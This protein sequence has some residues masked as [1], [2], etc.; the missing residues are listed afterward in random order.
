MKIKIMALVLMVLMVLTVAAC[1]TP[2]DT[3]NPADTTPSQGGTPSGDPTVETT[4]EAGPGLEAVDYEG[5]EFLVLNL[6]PN[7]ST[8]FPYAEILAE[9][10]DGTT[11]NDAVYE[12]NEVLN[13]KYNIK[14]VSQIEESRA[15]L[16]SAVTTDVNSGDASYDLI[17][18]VP[19]YSVVLASQ[20][21]LYD[22]TNLPYVNLE[23]D[24]WL[25]E[26][27]NEISIGEKVYYAPNYANICFLSAT[28]IVYFDKEMITSFELDSPYAL[29]DSGAWTLDQFIKLSTGVTSQHT[30]SPED[31][32]GFRMHPGSWGFMYTGLGGMLIDKD[33]DDIP[34]L[35]IDELDMT[36]LEAIAGLS[37]NAGMGFYC[38]Y[39]KVKEAFTAGKTLFVVQGAYDLEYYRQL[40]DFGIV[41]VP[42]WD[43]NQAEYISTVHQ[44]W[45]SFM[46]VEYSQPEDK[47]EMISAI[48]ED[49][50]YESLQIVK[51]AYYDTVLTGRYAKDAES[52]RMLDI[53][54]SN[55]T[56][57]LGILFE[58]YGIGV[59]GSVRGAIKTGN[60]TLT[61]AIKT[62]QRLNNSLLKN[63]IDAFDKYADR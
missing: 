51:P 47:L 7:H 63:V 32:V 55:V 8:N 58:Y 44:D 9:S 33:A 13:A 57:D 31:T 53:V 20:G 35:Q 12:R 38:E 48:M 5:A 1:A 10:M 27:V 56:I 45:G 19:T 50:A 22:Y 26:I 30:S 41:P 61:S 46:S 23:A 49:M 28:G 39:D 16:N 14:I 59:D 2:G 24:W 18:Q 25:S 62:Q 21:M 6:D 43:A 42:K 60:T 54:Y 17:M 40:A 11:I 15:K 29:V 34:V 52:A 3:T 4:P 37:T 36:K